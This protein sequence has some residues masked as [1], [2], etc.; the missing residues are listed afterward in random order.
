MA[1]AQAACIPETHANYMFSHQQFNFFD[2]YGMRMKHTG[3]QR[4]SMVF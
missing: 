4:H 1:F 3:T 2:L